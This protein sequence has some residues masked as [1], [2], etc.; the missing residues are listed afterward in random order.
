[1]GFYPV[2]K[3]SKDGD[4]TTLDNQLVLPTLILKTDGFSSMYQD[5]FTISHFTIY[6]KLSDFELVFIIIQ[7]SPKQVGG[8]SYPATQTEALSYQ[9]EVYLYDRFKTSFPITNCITIAVSGN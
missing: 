6:L 3:I 4:A 9:N 2:S 5:R 1:M 7:Y 8:S